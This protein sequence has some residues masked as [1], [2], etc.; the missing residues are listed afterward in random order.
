MAK[1]ET[2][3]RTPDSWG[4]HIYYQSLEAAAPLIQEMRQHEEVQYGDPE[5]ISADNFERLSLRDD[6]RY[7]DS[8]DWS[9]GFRVQTV[10][11][12]S[13]TSEDDGTMTV[14]ATESERRHRNGSR[15]VAA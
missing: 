8:G 10:Q 7:E 4:E 13:L 3:Y 5:S 11:I 9:D 6:G 2:V 12:V 1:L 14:V 15:M